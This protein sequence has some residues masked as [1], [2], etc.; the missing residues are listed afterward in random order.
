M[1]QKRYTEEEMRSVT[2]PQVIAE[3]LELEGLPEQQ[4]AAGRRRIEREHSLI[5]GILDVANPPSLAKVEKMKDEPRVGSM[6]ATDSARGRMK[7]GWDEM[8]KP[9]TPTQ[10]GDSGPKGAKDKIKQGFAE[11]HRGETDTDVVKDVTHTTHP[12]PP[13]ETIADRK[14]KGD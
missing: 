10:F 12:L 4:A 5:P 13:L 2:S 7:A 6:G 9:V 14:V 3:L 11:W 1:T 8:H